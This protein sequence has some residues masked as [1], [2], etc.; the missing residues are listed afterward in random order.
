M[1]LELLVVSLAGFVLVSPVFLVAWAVHHRMDID[2]VG[3]SV[4]IV[5]V[6]LA[7]LVLLGCVPPKQPCMTGFEIGVNG[8]QNQ[9]QQFGEGYRENNVGGHATVYFDTTGACRAE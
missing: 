9:G 2:P 8:G 1:L 6:I 7:L 5:C 3:V 4:F